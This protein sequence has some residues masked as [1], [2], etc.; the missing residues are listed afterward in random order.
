MERILGHVKSKRRYN[1][2][3]RLEQARRNRVA[4][5][6]AAERQL[7]ERGYAG[8]TVAAIAEE[9]G[10]SV[11]TIYKAF[12][13]KAGLVRA[14]YERGLAGAGPVPAYERSDDMREH[15]T[16]PRTIMREWGLLTAEVASLVTPIR[17]L[18]RSAAVHD[19]EM[20][21]LLEDIDNERL[22]RMRHHARYL[23]DRGYLREGV[24]VG[25]ATDILWVC[26]SAELYEL[27]VTKRGWSLQRFA[28]YVTQFMVVSLLP[29]KP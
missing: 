4:I 12:G 20:A 22:K 29:E 9:A 18:M 5:L 6:E 26:S 16:D 1:S 14:L 10:V 24:S 13:G 11:E 8:A 15:E 27:L 7:G 23:K 28:Q 17:L 25:E 19:Q 2:S 21:S 3:G